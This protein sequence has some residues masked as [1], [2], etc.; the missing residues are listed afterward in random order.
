MVFPVLYLILSTQRE[1]TGTDDLSTVTELELV[2]D[3]TDESIDRL[4]ER[5]PNLTHVSYYSHFVA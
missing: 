2:V 4:G 3:T 1:L 5:L